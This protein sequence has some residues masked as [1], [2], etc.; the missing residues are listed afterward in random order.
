[1][2]ASL[3]A[4]GGAPRSP[5]R[6]SLQSPASS[7]RGIPS[8][9]FLSFLF[10]T[11]TLVVGLGLLRSKDGVNSRSSASVAFAKNFIPNEVTF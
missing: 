5:V 1:M 6:P 8:H 3:L 4:S 10:V 2:P 9:L 7:P 11:G